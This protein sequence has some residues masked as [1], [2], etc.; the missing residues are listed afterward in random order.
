MRMTQLPVLPAALAASCLPACHPATHLTCFLSMVNSSFLS[1]IVR[2]SRTSSRS[3]YMCM[4]DAAA[5]VMAAA[6]AEVRQSQLKIRFYLPGCPGKHMVLTGRAARGKDMN[7]AVLLCESC[8]LFLPVALRASL[9]Q[10]RFHWCFCDTSKDR[11]ATQLCVHVTSYRESTIAVV[12]DHLHI[13]GDRGMPSTLLQGTKRRCSQASSMACSRALAFWKRLLMHVM[14]ELGLL[15]LLLVADLVCG[16]RCTGS[17][18]CI[19]CFAIRVLRSWCL[20]CMLLC[21]MSLSSNI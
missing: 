16:C 19:R 20:D 21:K 3:S 18:C 15:Q 6:A 8:M 13:A 5:A 11:L 9:G 17:G 2:R 14:K 7:M 10:T 4:A 12:E 1:P